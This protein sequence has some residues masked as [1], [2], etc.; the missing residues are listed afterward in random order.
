LNRLMIYHPIIFTIFI[1]F[2]QQLIIM[3]A[4][5]QNFKYVTPLFYFL[6]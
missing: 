1:T 4:T 3:K 2:V 6:E 5:P